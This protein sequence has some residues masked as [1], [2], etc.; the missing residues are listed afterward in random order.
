M[1][2]R[3][4]EHNQTAYDAVLSML[5]EKK[6]AAV[7]HPTGTGK[8]FIGFKLC[9][10]FPDSIVCWLSPSEYI[11]NTQIENLRKASGG[12]APENIK[13]FTYAKLMNMTEAELSEIKP[14]YVIFDEFHR[15]GAEFWGMGVDNLLNMYSYVPIVG[16][17]ATAIRYL[18]NAR[19]MSDELFDGNVAS[20]ITLGEAIV[21]GILNPPKYVLSVF[22]FADD[23][24]N[25][26]RRVRNSRNKF[27]RDEGEK[28]LE[29]LR[30]A[31]EKADGLEEIFKK[32]IEDKTGK[33][34]VFCS[35][36]E[37]LNEMVRVSK[38]WFKTI[39]DAPH[40]YIAYSNNAETSKAFSNF[41]KDNSDH[42]KLLYCI[43]M[44]NEGVHVDDISGVILLRPTVSPIIY[45]QQI[46]RALATGK[47]NSAVIFDIV[48]NIENLYSIG[49]IEEEMHITASYY[50][51]LGEE[52]LIVNE[53]FKV[54]DEVRECRELFDKLEG[55]LT[56][57]WDIMYG[58]AQK[59][60]EEH[61]NL[62]VP[63]RYA[64]P[65]GYSLGHW[66][67]NQR[68]VRK[69][70][71]QGVLTDEQIEK[72]DRLQMRWNYFTDNSWET[73]FAAAQKY[74]EEHGNLDMPAKY[75]T[76]D[77]L[78]LGAWIS[79]LRSWE[80]AGLHPKYL[81]AERRKMLEDLGMIWNKLNHVWERNFA[82]A[83]KFYKENGHLQV[84]AK[85][86][87]PDGIK[88]GNWISYL[89]NVRIG[90][91]KRGAALTEEQIA[92]LDSIGMSWNPTVADKWEDG[93]KEAKIY[94][95][96]NGTL[97]VPVSYVSESGYKLGSWLQRQNKLL[98]NEE[99]LPE[100]KN[101]LD[102]LGVEWIRKDPWML[103]YEVLL[104]YYSET[105]TLSI[106]NDLVYEGVW[107]GKWLSS[108][109]K[110]YKNGTV[111]ND[112]QRALIAKLINGEKTHTRR[113]ESSSFDSRA[114]LN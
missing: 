82:A 63:A 111:L 6:K 31:L 34:I 107:I 27:I 79:N 70:Q 16:F 53:R 41:K 61:G 91:Q 9:E 19:D 38:E 26:Q 90:K 25:Y 58:Y 18:D 114:T 11:F 100:R 47:K 65:D 56:A 113:I 43:D 77:G 24:A 84:P 62:E 110:Y 78:R 68:A 72:L 15:C 106:P 36:F 8:S 109:K 64:T 95:Q 35:N 105:G 57:S 10:D 99:L 39:D 80:S 5:S 28:Y 42:M 94:A 102:S 44:L 32:H 37:H 50:R 101:K 14:D 81:S 49:A 7:I 92:R 59:Y 54:I 40:V 75:I 98:K 89:K 29:A 67:Y 20:E 83:E 12:Y 4:F 85:Y 52:R 69:G 13:F 17:S 48:M 108:Q 51:D 103:R 86:V 21:R 60:Y 2:I 3:L 87:S 55:I 112:E 23:L 104:K 73:N 93:F 74:Y 46:G 66:I 96:N 97:L 88:L 33:Y 76:E 30:H 71:M 22:S 1:A 45:K